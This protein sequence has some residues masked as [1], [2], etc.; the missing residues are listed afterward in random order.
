MKEGWMKNDEGWRLNDEGWWF[1]AVKGF[2]FMT[3]RQMNEWTISLILLLKTSFI[4]FDGE[5]NVYV[6]VPGLSES[7]FYGT[8]LRKY[9]TEHWEEPLTFVTECTAEKLCNTTNIYDHLQ[10]LSNCYINFEMKDGVQVEIE[11][12]KS[13]GEDDIHKAVVHP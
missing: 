3:D 1:L 12:T 9:G 8:R 13:W 4:F 2:W 11:V 7:Q 6:K 5:V 10:D